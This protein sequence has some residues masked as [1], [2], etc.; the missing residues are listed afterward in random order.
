[1]FHSEVRK[2]PWF[3]YISQFITEPIVK[4]CLGSLYLAFLAKI[5]LYL[6]FTPVP[7]TFQTFGVYSLGRI[8]SP[9][10]AVVTVI[11]YLVGGLFFPVFCGNSCGWTVFCGPTA[12]YLLAFAPSIALISWALPKCMNRMQQTCVFLCASTL[13]LTVGSLW[14][15]WYLYIVGVTSSL[16]VS[17]ALVLGFLPFIPGDMVKIALVSLGNVFLQRQGS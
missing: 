12:G 1:M 11:A 2:L 15:C 7:I 14:L 6:P 3:S 10:I 9:R 13:I 8:F 16:N 5:C 4:V 17:N